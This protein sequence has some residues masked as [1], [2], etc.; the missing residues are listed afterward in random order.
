MKPFACEK[1]PLVAEA[2]RCGRWDDDLRAHVANCEACSDAMLAAS[3]L[4]ALRESDHAA[5]PV[6]DAGRVWWKAQLQA[7]R[8]AA[9]RAARPISIAQWAAFACAALAFAGVCA[10]HWAAVRA[11][12]G[13]FASNWHVSGFAVP[14]F[15]ANLWQSSSVTLIMSGSAFLVFL[16]LVVYL[17]WSED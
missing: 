11:W 7:R 10:W 12:F 5:A 6:P 15:V 13:A 14:Q 17:V 8:Q 3:F 4:F 16:S 9:E 2:A 1:E